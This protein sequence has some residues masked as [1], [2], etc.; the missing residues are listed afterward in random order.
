MELA[1]HQINAVSNAVNLF[2]YV[3]YRAIFR[4]HAEKS[5][6]DAKLLT[7]ILVME[8]WE[9]SSKAVSTRKLM[10]FVAHENYS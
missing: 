4:K 8:A 1:L 5:Q 10:D 7:T 3:Q 9:I 2:I 6:F